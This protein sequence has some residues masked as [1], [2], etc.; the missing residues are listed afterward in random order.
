MVPSRLGLLQPLLAPCRSWQHTHKQLARG[1]TTGSLASQE[2]KSAVTA[3]NSGA[4]RGLSWTKVAGR[5]SAVP[6]PPQGAGNR[7][8]LA[9]TS[10]SA[11]QQGLH[12]HGLFAGRANQKIVDERISASAWSTGLR[13]G[14]LLPRA[15]K[16]A[17]PV[18]VD[19]DNCKLYSPANLL[20][21]PI[22]TNGLAGST[23]FQLWKKEGF[24]CVKAISMDFTLALPVFVSDRRGYPSLSAILEL[25]QACQ[26]KRWA[27]L[28]QYLITSAGRKGTM[29]HEEHPR[30]ISLKHSGQELDKRWETQAGIAGKFWVFT[31]Q[32]KS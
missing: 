10:P 14:A 11:F 12:H 30:V 23:E 16:H 20:E 28:K 22:P 29:Y 19:Q 4:L 24:L 27:A 2:V 13:H 31:V 25:W 3:G 1:L 15:V 5:S 26:S 21:G 32:K 18:L 17:E 9:Q 7:R 8:T 6:A